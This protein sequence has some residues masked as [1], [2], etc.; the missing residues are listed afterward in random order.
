MKIYQVYRQKWL[1]GMWAKEFGKL[2]FRPR[3]MN[4]L[5][6]NRIYIYRG[7]SDL[8]ADFVGER[9]DLP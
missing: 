9:I 3:G 4:L 6:H 1:F 2:A 5:E 7:I 8:W